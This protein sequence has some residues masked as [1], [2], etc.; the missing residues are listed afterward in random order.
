MFD[1]IFEEYE[2][3]MNDMQMLH[4]YIHEN[5]TAP[6]LDPPKDWN[7]EMLRRREWS[8]ISFVKDGD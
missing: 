1:F 5:E 7:P 3:Y 4:D 6:N 2:K 8:S